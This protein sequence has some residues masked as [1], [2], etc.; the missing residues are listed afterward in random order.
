M[1]LPWLLR[2]WL[3]R[4]ASDKLRQAA[5]EA[6]TEAARKAASQQQTQAAPPD[7]RP[8]CHAAF[9][10]ALSQEAGGLEDRLSGAV[11]IRAHGF[12][13]TE[14][15]LGGRR[16]V[17]ARTGADP[18]AAA[19]IAAAIIEGHQPWWMIAAGFAGGLSSQ[20]ARGEIVLADEVVTPAGNRLAFD[21]PAG[22]RQVSWPDRFHVHFGRLVSVD[23][24]VG[25]PA[26]KKQ[27]GGALSAVAVDMESAAVAEVCRREKVPCVSVRIITDGVDDEL[28]AEIDHLAKQKTLAGKLGAVTGAVFRRPSSAKDM[29]RLKETALVSSDRLA[30]FLEL[31]MPVLAPPK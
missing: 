30:E 17:I 13:A 27:L 7:E 15:S 4:Q 28:P 26:E 8:V 5:Q 3:A 31:L 2:G 22:L 20:I 6:M 19:R 16:V 10:F 24:I 9:L 12:S 23:H 14:G 18:K 1:S 21:Q 25:K 11:S 29:L